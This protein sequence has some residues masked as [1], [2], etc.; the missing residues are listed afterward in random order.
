MSVVK[1][2]LN[3][4]GRNYSK[5]YCHLDKV[6]AI[7]TGLRQN[8]L[9]KREL[10]KYNTVDLSVYIL[11]KQAASIRAV[12]RQLRLARDSHTCTDEG[13]KPPSN[14]KLYC[15]RKFHMGNEQSTHISIAN[16]LSRISLSS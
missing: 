12:I 10:N 4:F 6:L 14:G 7:M 3:D 5:F 1:R 13:P 16:R 9:I 11:E 8:F 15:K 2:D